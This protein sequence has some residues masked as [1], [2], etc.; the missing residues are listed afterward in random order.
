M[1]FSLKKAAYKKILLLYG[2]T[3]AH[4]RANDGRHDHSA[5]ASTT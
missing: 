5:A 4:P 1:A 2:V 3:A